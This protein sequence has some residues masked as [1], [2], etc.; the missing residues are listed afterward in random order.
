M[1][2]TPCKAGGLMSRVVSK[3][4]GTIRQRCTKACPSSPDIYNVHKIIKSQNSED[5]VSGLHSPLPVFINST[6][7]QLS[8]FSDNIIYEIWITFK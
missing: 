6:V 1:S 4:V 5:W 7:F 3:A 8:I 2:D